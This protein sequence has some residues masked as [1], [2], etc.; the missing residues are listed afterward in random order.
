MIREAFR[1]LTVDLSTRR[2]RVVL[3]EERERY[4]GGSGL[5]ALLFDS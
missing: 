1:V 3:L 4:L 2:S 5:A